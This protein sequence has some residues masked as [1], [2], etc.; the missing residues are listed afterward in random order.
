MRFVPLPGLRS[1]GDQVLGECT[2]PGGPCILSPP[3]S[4]LLCFLGALQE[5]YLRCA[6]CL[7][8]RADLRLRPSWWLST[9]QDLRKTWLAARSLLT[10]WRKVPSLG[11]RLQQPLAFQ[12][13]AVFL[14][15]GG[16]GP[17][18]SQLSLLWYSLSPL[19]CQQASLCLR[20]LG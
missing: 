9:I 11:F 14:P 2:R 6:I 20:L 18:C 17:V 7:L 12:L 16:E 4:W 1:S 5:N 15:P 10:V 8:W 3:W 13:W 19:F